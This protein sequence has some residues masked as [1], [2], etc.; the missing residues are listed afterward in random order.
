[1]RRPA[2]SLLILLGGV[3][4][5]LGCNGAIGGGGGSVLSSNWS[6]S[7]AP[8]IFIYYFGNGNT[9]G[10]VPTQVASSSLGETTTIL[11]NTGNLVKAGYSFAG[12]N[13]Q[14]DG[15]G[16]TYQPGQTFVMGSVNMALYALWVAN[17]VPAVTY[18]GNDNTGGSAPSDPGT[19]LEG[20]SV[21]VLGNTG[22]LVRNGAPF[23]GWNTRADGTGTTYVQ[24]QSFPMGPA[25]VTLHAIYGDL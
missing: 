5:L 18:V 10:A 11:G 20:Q 22:A 17:A 2:H 24:G 8:L 14:P 19:Y 7:P 1:M 9:G 13:T 23:K 25:P 21:T 3:L 6:T 15:S 12:W 16:T 4:L